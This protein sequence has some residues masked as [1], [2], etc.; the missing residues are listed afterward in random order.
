MLLFPL[1]FLFFFCHQTISTVLCCHFQSSLHHGL[2]FLNMVHGAVAGFFGWV[3]V[4]SL[5]PLQAANS[6][7][8]AYKTACSLPCDFSKHGFLT[9]FY[10]RNTYPLVVHPILLCYKE[11]FLYNRCFT[12]YFTVP[13]L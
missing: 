9:S 3:F 7:C 8:F 13:F 1:D 5:S 6:M 10:F 2:F 12:K 4:I 11:D